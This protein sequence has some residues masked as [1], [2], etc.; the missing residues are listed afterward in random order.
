MAMTG[1]YTAFSDTRI[2]AIHTTHYENPDQSTMKN[3]ATR[4]LL[5]LIEQADSTEQ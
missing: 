5:F 3:M 1:E 2:L 4:Y